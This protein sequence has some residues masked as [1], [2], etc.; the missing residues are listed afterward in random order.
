MTFVLMSLFISLA[1]VSRIA[2]FCDSVIA[3][4]QICLSVQMH[5]LYRSRFLV[6]TLC[7]M[8]FCSSYAEAQRF[9]K[10]AANCVAG[11]ILG[12]DA[13]VSNKTLLFAADNVDHNILTIDGKGTFHGM[14]MIAALTPRQETLHKIPRHKTAVLN[15]VDKSTIVIIDLGLSK[16]AKRPTRVTALASID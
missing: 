6:D 8:G 15:I 12:E 11:N 1:A 7:E 14:G 10:N 5:H 16:V 9:E 2:L 4:L 13:D 3:P